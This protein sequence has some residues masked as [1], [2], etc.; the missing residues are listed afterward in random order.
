MSV[1]I[2]TLEVL[3]TGFNSWQPNVTWKLLYSS[4]HGTLMLFRDGR[5]GSDNTEKYCPR[6]PIFSV[7]EILYLGQYFP[8]FEGAGSV[9]NITDDYLSQ[10]HPIAIEY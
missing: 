10:N 7:R 4:Q 1:N 6:P 2:D 9:L 5:R 8:L 3:R